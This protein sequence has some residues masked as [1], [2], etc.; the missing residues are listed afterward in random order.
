MNNNYSDN[1]FE[2]QNGSLMIDPSFCF[3][4]SNYNDYNAFYPSAYNS[5]LP[6]SSSLPDD[7]SVLTLPYGNEEETLEGPTFSLSHDAI[8][9]ANSLTRSSSIQLPFLSPRHSMEGTESYSQM[10]PFQFGLVPF[11]EPYSDDHAYNHSE[12]VLADSTPEDTIT[13]SIM[14]DPLVVVPDQSSIMKPDVQI[15]QEQSSDDEWINNMCVTET[16]TGKGKPVMWTEEECNRLREAVKI[17]GVPGSWSKI[18]KYV[19]TRSSSQCI[20]KWKNDLCKKRKRWNR[21]ATIQLA[22]YLKKGMSEEEIAKK[23]SEYTYIQLYQQMRKY[24]TNQSPWE[25]WEIQKLAEYKRQ[26]ILSNTQIGG[27][28]NNRHCDAVKNMWNRIKHQYK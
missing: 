28:L 11:E 22:S 23:M 10:Q 19:G 2:E 12:V 9:R 18:A 3:S 17:Y 16:Q 6:Y 7:P 26:G 1:T 27:K 21:E 4:F 8:S 13:D 20:N 14:G 24:Y 15:E 5:S 25:E